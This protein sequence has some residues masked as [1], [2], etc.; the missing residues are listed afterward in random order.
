LTVVRTYS[1]A[2]HYIEWT[3]RGVKSGYKA[4]IRALAL[5]KGLPKRSGDA[6]VDAF[7][8]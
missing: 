8:A 5:R 4:I 2:L 1:D 7:F 6:Q 3:V